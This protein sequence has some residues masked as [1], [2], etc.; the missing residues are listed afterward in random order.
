MS[1]FAPRKAETPGHLARRFQQFAVAAFQ[2][3]M[4]LIGSDIT[5]VQYAAMVVLAEKPQIDQA[6][7]ASAIALDRATI[8]GVLGR[9]EGKGLIVRS[10]SPADRRARE[11]RLTPEGAETLARIKP[12][13]E[14][15]QKN[16]MKKLSG[17][18][19]VKLMQLLNK[20]IG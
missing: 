1:K 20:A 12:H 14:N 10:V 17:A 7:L 18:E 5:P 13:V 8:T 4:D 15:A 2:S 19:A 11:L 6:T 9:L 16:I 3:E